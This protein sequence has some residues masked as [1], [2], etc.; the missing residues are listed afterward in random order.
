MT[1]LERGQVVPLREP[2]PD[3]HADELDALLVEVP[4]DARSAVERVAA[5]ASRLV[6]AT[7]SVGW[8]G[9]R[10]GTDGCGVVRAGRVALH[11][12]PTVAVT[13]ASA[14]RLRQACAWL[15]LAGERDEA[16]RGADMAAAEATVI[17]DVVERLLSVRDVDQVLL[18]IA[19]HTL[20]LLDSDNCGVLLREGDEVRMRS[21]VG[22]R[23]IDTARLR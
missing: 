14:R 12:D 4:P 10:V 7:V 17:R 18:S 19:D 2:G 6:G 22:N 1:P 5:A 13:P 11:W 9:R 23:V 8:E 15:S 3:V 20:R 21:C 16:V